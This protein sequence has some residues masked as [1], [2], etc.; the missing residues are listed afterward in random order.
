MKQTREQLREMFGIKAPAPPKIPL[1]ADE[2]LPIIKIADLDLFNENEFADPVG[3]TFG[4]GEK[5]HS[6]EALGF[7]SAIAS[8]LNR[9]EISRITNRNGEIIDR[10]YRVIG[11]L[12]AGGASEVYLCERLLVG[13]KVALKMMRANY[14][15]DPETAR[16]FHSEALTTAS[17]KHPNVITIHDFDFTEGGIPFMVMELLRGQTLLGEL[18]RLG[19]IPLRQ[20]LQIMTPICSALNVAHKNGIVHRDLK[21]ANIVLQRM[22][23][24]TEVVKLIDFGIAKQF[25]QGGVNPLKTLPGMVVGTPAYMSPERCLEE[26]Y[27]AR[28]DIYNLG[29][30]FYEMITG[31]H[32]FQAKTMMAMMAK[33]ISEKPPSLRNI[34]PE[35]SEPLE[36]TV[37]KALAKTPEERFSTA[38]EFADELNS[39]F[40]ASWLQ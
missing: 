2:T 31:H 8:P 5:L 34:L 30:I 7:D 27:D 16:R 11:P 15:I 4:Y 13:D 6:D 3:Y 9:Q 24:N 20:A 25:F 38:L 18:K 17:I 39:S 29:L 19:R 28:A 14:S 10:K 37:F 12:G 22:D 35:V 32:P 1:G 26:P 40:Y 23:D 36:K 21:P 33:Q